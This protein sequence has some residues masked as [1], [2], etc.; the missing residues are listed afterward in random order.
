MF[1]DLAFTMKS[2]LIGQLAPMALLGIGAMFTLWLLGVPL[3]F[4][5]ALLTSAMLFMPYIGSVIA[6]VPTGLVALTQGPEKLLAVT[7][8]LSGYSS[9]RGLRPHSARAAAGRQ[10]A[11]SADVNGSVMPLGIRRSV[12]C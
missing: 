6:Y 7:A 9:R 10:S 3:A 11:T 4:T 12:G 8:V 5:L 2:W 1:Q